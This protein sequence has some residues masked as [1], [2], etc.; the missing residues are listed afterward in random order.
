MVCEGC[1]SQDGSCGPGLVCITTTSLGES[2]NPWTYQSQCAHYCCDDGDCGS[3]T[4][5]K[6]VLGSSIVGVCLW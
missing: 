3:G 6:T 2:P 1:T 4:C 5:D